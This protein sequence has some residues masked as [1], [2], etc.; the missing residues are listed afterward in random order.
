MS[1]E[2]IDQLKV[3][4]GVSWSELGRLAGVSKQSVN[5]WKNGG[6]IGGRSALNL[7][8]R[9]NVNPDWL[10][11]G[12]GQM[13]LKRS[14]AMRKIEEL[15]SSLPADDQERAYRMLAA[16]YNSDKS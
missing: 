11:Y 7:Q 2:R 12:K 16:V 4:L 3:E 8:K 1:K 9:A 15:I 10:L 14:E 13:F 5:D 6:P